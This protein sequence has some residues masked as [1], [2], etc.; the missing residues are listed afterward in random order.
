MNIKN[1][2]SRIA[3]LCLA[4]A[5]LVVVGAAQAD[6]CKNVDIVVD[7]QGSQT[8]EVLSMDFRAHTDNQDRHEGL[9]NTQVAAGATKT[10]GANQN[11]AGIEG[12]DMKSIT[13]HYKAWCAG[14][15]KW[16]AEKTWTDT[17][18]LAP[19]CVSGGKYT[20]QIPKRD[21]CN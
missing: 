14:A 17:K 1:I 3:A 16:S 8:I 20:V 11:L 19:K 12:Y 5:A 7:N 4:T 21:E 13:I 9:P 18:F 10:V 15:N 6:T 2:K